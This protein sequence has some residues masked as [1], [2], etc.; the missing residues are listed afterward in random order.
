MTKQTALISALMILAFTLDSRARETVHTWTDD[1]GVVHYSDRP[2]S[3]NSR[4]ME[5]EDSNVLESVLA[6][7]P[8]VKQPKARRTV[9][10]RPTPDK[11]EE[12]CFKARQRVDSIRAKRRHGYKASED[13]RLRQQLAQAQERARFYC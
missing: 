11:Q 2:T 5:V 10:N 13:R 8:E 6:T 9:Q 7:V 3:A 1:R 12:Q 4:A